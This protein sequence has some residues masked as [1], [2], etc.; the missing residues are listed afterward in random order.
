MA[1][2]CTKETFLQHVENH[3]INIKHD[4][5]V[6]RHIVMSDGSSNRRYEITTFPQHLCY[7]GDMGSFVF[8]RVEDMFTFFRG[9]I[10]SE[11][12]INPGYWHE[13][14]EAEDRD[15]GSVE[16]SPQAFRDVI[17]GYLSDASEVL[18]AEQIQTIWQEI[19]CDVNPWLEDHEIR[20]YDAADKF[21]CEGFTFVDLWDSNFKEYTYRF[22]WCLYAIVYA[23]QEYDKTNS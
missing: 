17:M 16:Y 19:K 9:D 3:K 22:I 18:D 7:T 23:I 21:E 15:G 20:A 6:Y 4:D 12:A 5:G 1:Y 14:V 2:Q 8:R 13:K 10:N 11:Y